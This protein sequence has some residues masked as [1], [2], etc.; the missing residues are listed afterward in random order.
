MRSGSTRADCALNI[1]PREQ[2][3]NCTTWPLLHRKPSGQSPLEHP[4]RGAPSSTA[5]RK[6]QADLFSTQYCPE[7]PGPEYRPCSFCGRVTQ[8]KTACGAPAARLQACSLVLERLCL[9]CLAFCLRKKC[10]PQSLGFL[11][12]RNPRVSMSHRV[13]WE[14]GV[15]ENRPFRGR[16]CWG[17][18]LGGPAGRD[19][20]KVSVLLASGLGQGQTLETVWLG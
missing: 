10:F 11:L 4:V 15:S 19:E 9:E 8:D 13:G 12:R 2:R 5:L 6:H 20:G 18:G 1:F 16:S 3:V 7:P 17:P 14:D